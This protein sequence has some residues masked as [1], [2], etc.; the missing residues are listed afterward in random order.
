MDARVIQDKLEALRHCVQRVQ[1]KCPASVETLLA[2]ADLQDIVTLNLTR[3][4]Q[5][6]VDMALHL[7]ADT[8]VQPPETMAAAFES[9]ASLP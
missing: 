6:S 7:I 4:V 9:A 8:D 1:E 5:L 3:A 2:D